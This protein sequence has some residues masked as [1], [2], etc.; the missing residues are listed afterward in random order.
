MT[1][2]KTPRGQ[3][4]IDLAEAM[5]KLWQGHDLAVLGAAL[6]QALAIFLAAHPETTREALDHMHLASVRNA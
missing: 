4:A 3:N 1:H 2:E 5:T 6:A